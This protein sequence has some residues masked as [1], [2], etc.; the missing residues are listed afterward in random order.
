MNKLKLGI[1]LIILGNLL[2]VI[3]ISVIGSRVGN[4][5]DFLRG[6]F[7]GLSV[8]SNIIGIILVVMYVSKLPDT[9]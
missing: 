6:L 1:S 2:Y 9:K 7:L 8:G 5:S 3:D 4:V